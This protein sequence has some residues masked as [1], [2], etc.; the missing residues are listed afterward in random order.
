M[1]LLWTKS[2]HK[3]ND[4]W[5]TSKATQYLDFSKRLVHNLPT[6]S[7]F[8]KPTLWSANAKTIMIC[9]QVHSHNKMTTITSLLGLKPTVRGGGSSMIA[10]PWVRACMFARFDCK[11]FFSDAMPDCQYNAICALIQ[12]MKQ[13]KH[14]AKVGR[15]ALNW[16]LL[17]WKQI[18]LKTTTLT[19]SSF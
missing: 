2:L 11:N 8:V 13:L 7:M 15:L 14:P 1:L 4:I 18:Q 19:S 3:T 10:Y 17:S 5:M 16:E 9:M 12:N 6:K